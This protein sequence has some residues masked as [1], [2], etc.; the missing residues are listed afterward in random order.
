M[1]RLSPWLLAGLLITV[2]AEPG[3]ARAGEELVDGIAAQVGNQIVLVS[4]VLAK[5]ADT[6]H[7]MVEAGAPQSEIYKL[8]ADGL[9]RM[10]EQKI[11]ENE[12]QRLELRASD[13]E[14]DQVISALASENNITLAQL[15]DSVQSQGMTMEEYRAEIRSKVEQRKVMTQALQPKVN[16]EEQELRD[17]YVA[18]FADQPTGGMQ[19]HLRHILITVEP[20]RE[21]SIACD[22]TEAAAARIRDGEPFE[23]VAS[24]VSAV[25]PESG[26]DIGW[27]HADSLARW[28]S[29]LVKD[30][31][32]GEVSQI[33]RQPFGCNILKLVERKQ[34]EPITFEQARPS[35]EQ[36]LYAQKIEAEYT[37]WM[38]ELR[39]HTY[40]K[41]RGY[42]ADAASFDL[43]T[44][45]EDSEVGK[46]L[47]Q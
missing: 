2:I 42:F 36:A 10:I 43:E 41:R 29:D 11:I 22:E 24:E 40:I 25:S 28:M 44:D 12:V 37:T 39:K 3:S 14:I 9:E 30:L 19:V 47:F 7:R 5:V 33:S 31:K 23:V 13:A 1:R 32:P 26:G 45:S 20:G 16:I 8:R 17:L 46:S 18:R 6:E 34:Y 38:D 15:A 21:I 35:L 4:E 27:V